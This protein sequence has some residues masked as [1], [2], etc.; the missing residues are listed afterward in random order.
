M[1]TAVIY[2]RVSSGRQE[3]EGFSI[4]AQIE[5]LTEYAKQNNFS[6]EAQFVEAETAKKAGRKQFN[7]ML[8]YISEHNIDAILAEKTDR[9]Y[10][11]LKD[12]LTLDEFKQLEVHLV[13]ENMIISEHSSSHIK[14][15]HGIKV[16]M[17]KQ[18]IDNLSEEV[19]KG[20]NRKAKEGYYPQQA[21]VGYMN[22]DGPEGKRIIVPDP[23]NG[24]FIAKLFTMY[25][26]GT[27]SIAALRKLLYEEG[28]NHKG[29]PYSKARLLAILHDPFYIGKFMY[30]GALY[31][32]KHEPLVPDEIFYSVQRSFNQSKARKHDTEFLYTGLLK[33]GHC[34]CQLTA[35]LKKGKYVYYHCTG[36]RGG[37]CRKDYI[38]EEQIDEV[39]MDLI[40][41]IPN[42]DSKI[43]DLI[44]AGIKETRR[45]K[46]EYEEHSVE[47]IEK[48]IK[49]LQARID[50]LYTDKLDGRITEEFWKEKHNL[51]YEEKDQLIEKLKSINNAARTF[52]EGT[53]LLENFCKHAPRLYERACPKTKQEILKIIG[54]NFTYKDKKVSVELTSVFELLLNNPF[55]KNG[56]IYKPKLE[57]R[58][59][60]Y[61][62]KKALS[63]EFISSL[64]ALNFAA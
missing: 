16:L 18:Y 22:T 36:K 25:N 5:F 51:W 64:K 6:I 3:R 24:P 19:K 34:G 58:Q 56:G 38:R 53:N 7:N 46:G 50:N 44:R 20:K 12:Y 60:I 48:Q 28:F 49:R 31:Q 62:L 30:N 26:H 27:Y 41:K 32:G 23:A 42:P 55:S 37:D 4:P 52:D 63:Q 13:K 57:P 9:I 11:N 21:P 33:C 15:M 39:F 29:K 61:K 14:F 54:S 59:F 2:A 45:L 35:E 40:K 47:E 8:K 1:K 10:R 43:F 17:A